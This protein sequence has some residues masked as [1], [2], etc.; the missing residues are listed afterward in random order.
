VGTGAEEALARPRYLRN[1]EEAVRE[2]GNGKSQRCRAG[3]RMGSLYPVMAGTTQPGRREGP[4]PHRTH[5]E[6]HELRAF[7]CI[8]GD[9]T[10]LNSM[11][12]DVGL[13]PQVHRARFP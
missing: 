11:R 4:L 8:A 3:C 1:R 2:T 9:L 5:A 13:A 6:S 10:K 7:A 12:N